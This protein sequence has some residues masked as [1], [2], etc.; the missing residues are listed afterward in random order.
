[1]ALA[2]VIASLVL[3]AA[4][5]GGGEKGTVTGVVRVSRPCP[6][7]TAPLQPTGRPESASPVGQPGECD[8][9]VSGASVEVSPLGSDTVLSRVEAGQDGAF[10]LELSA[11]HYTLRAH[12]AEPSLGLAVPLDV[13]VEAGATVQ[14]ILRVD[15][16]VQ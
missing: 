13:T 5:G 3:G 4:C 11:G 14:V 1:M 16:G 12:P 9:L 2:A 10:T 8:E 6:V 15:T 7:E